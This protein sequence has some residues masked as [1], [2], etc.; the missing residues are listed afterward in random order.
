MIN[1]II[2]EYS[3]DDIKVGDVFEFKKVVTGKIVDEY[4]KLTGDFNPL[5][6]DEEYAKNTEFKGTIVHGMLAASFFSTLLGMVCPGK[7]NLYLT[8]S[9]N[10]KKPIFPNSEIIIRGIIKD[11]IESV[12]IIVVTTQIIYAGAIAVS[13][14]AKVKVR[15]E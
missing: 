5:H 9:L 4:A 11:K 8:Q 12:K 15:D 10:F 3:Y 2:N 14:E 13:G 7:R 6:C 1:M